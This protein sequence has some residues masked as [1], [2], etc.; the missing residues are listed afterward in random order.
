M[1]DPRVQ[2]I[3]DDKLVGRGTCSTIDECYTDGE[4]I[5]QL[6]SEGIHS[7]KE[8]VEWAVEFEGLRVEQATNARWGDSDDPQIEA[9]DDFEK[10]R[11]QWLRD[12]PEHGRE[13]NEG[14]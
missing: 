11:K 9:Y 3:R 2:A 7:T 6:D 14:R 5:E 12:N 4:L 8:S 10:R 1:S 13:D